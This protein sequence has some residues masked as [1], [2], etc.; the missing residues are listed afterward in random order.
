VK[1]DIACWRP[2]VRKG[3]LLAGHDY[4]HKGHPGVRKAVDEVYKVP[5]LTFRPGTVWLVEV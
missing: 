2:K 5:Q 4:G 3:G 1:E